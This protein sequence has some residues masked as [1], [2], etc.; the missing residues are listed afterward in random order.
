MFVSQE[1]EIVI[2]NDQDRTKLANRL[3]PAIVSEDRWQT[4]YP[5]ETSFMSHRFYRDFPRMY[6][7][8]LVFYWCSRWAAI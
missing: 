6:I 8:A 3:T 4:I 7:E 2:Y 5:Y 1:S